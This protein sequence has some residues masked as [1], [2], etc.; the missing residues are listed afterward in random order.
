MNTEEAPNLTKEAV[1][2]HPAAIGDYV[3]ATKYSDGDPQDHW[4][5][6]FYSGITASHYN[7]PRFDVVDGGGKLFRGNGFRRVK[8]I[9]AER[10]AWLLK[11]ASDIEFSGKSLWHFVRCSMD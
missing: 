4:V 6:G 2:A 8:K 10:G 11:H 5:V 9:S 7:P 1:E 3:L